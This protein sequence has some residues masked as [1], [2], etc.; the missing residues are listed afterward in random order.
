MASWFSQNV[1]RAQACQRAAVVPPDQQTL[2]TRTFVYSATPTTTAYP[3]DTIAFAT[4]EGIDQLVI[5]GTI[6][7]PN[8]V[9]Y[10]PP[11]TALL[12]LFQ[13][14]EVDAQYAIDVSNHGGNSVDLTIYKTNAYGT[15]QA[16][17]AYGQPFRQATI[18]AYGVVRLYLRVI[19]ATPTTGAADVKLLTTLEGGTGSLP[20]PVILFDM[21]TPR[22]PMVPT[23][24]NAVLM[25]QHVIPSVTGPAYQIVFGGTATAPGTILPPAVPAAG[26]CAGILYP[27]LP[28]TA[29]SASP[30][31]TPYVTDVAGALPLVSAIVAG[32]AFVY[33]LIA[34][35]QC[36]QTLTWTVPA[37][38]GV[39]PY[40]GTSLP[41]QPTGTTYRVD[42]RWLVAGVATTSPPWAGSTLTIHLNQ[43]SELNPNLY[44]V[45]YSYPTLAAR[46]SLATPLTI[47]YSVA[48]TITS[49]TIQNGV[50]PITVFSSAAPV[51]IGVYLVSY[52][53]NVPAT[54]G[55]TATLA[56][57]IGLAGTIQPAN[58]ATTIYIAA[59]WPG[60]ISSTGVVFVSTPGN[61]NFMA[62]ISSGTVAGCI[63]MLYSTRIG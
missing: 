47:G 4:L 11:A 30:A 46:T 16:G 34:S 9:V 54:G 37:T 13:S 7:A 29:A 21:G 52:Y 60:F 23:T 32:D 50:T 57:S 51:P 31:A 27:T 28:A 41:A 42:F 1:T 3:D 35:N 45:N 5:E 8:T 39:Q 49:S 36:G 53:V 24:N 43:V 62:C 10:M 17:V 44:T 14:P 38:T 26:N 20:M 19:D 22:Q 55:A 12:D 61:I 58:F 18:P 59:S 33:T 25:S 2:V 48:T 56:H 40:G 6:P 15:G 63:G